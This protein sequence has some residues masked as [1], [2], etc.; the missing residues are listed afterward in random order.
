M[1]NIFRSKRKRK[2]RLKRWTM[3]WREAECV[4]IED[5][6]VCLY[7]GSGGLSNPKLKVRLVGLVT[8]KKGPFG[9]WAVFMRSAKAITYSFFFFLVVPSSPL[10]SE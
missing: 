4:R 2:I 10:F 1:Y 5:E 3:L 8:K 6:W 7:I 9:H